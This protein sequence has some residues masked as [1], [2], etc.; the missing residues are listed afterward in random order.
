MTK[1]AMALCYNAHA[2]QVDKAGAP[3]V[4]HPYHLAEQM[5]NE[6]STTVALLHD[7]I[8][9]TNYTFDDLAREG[10]PDTVLDALRLLTHDKDVPYLDYVAKV[11]SNPVAVEVK[12]ADIEHNSDESR[13]D[14]VSPDVVRR[15]RKYVNAKKVL[16]AENLIEV[17]A[18]IIYDETGT[19]FL[20]CQRPENKT[21]GLLWEFVGGKVEPGE[22]KPDAL[23]RECREELAVEIEVTSRY[24]DVVHEYPDVT[25]LLTV[26]E[27]KIV[28]GEIKMLEH[29]DIRWVTPKEAQAMPFCPA[30]T[31]ILKKLS[32][33]QG[34]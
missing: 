32:G 24:M 25:V 34:I 2:G 7:V 3:Y 6:V 9:D 23:V 18:A 1:K 12:R 8:E 19:R 27:A 30:D 14:G 28:G 4:F 13:M 11:R 20:A 5:R 26:F 33:R 22:S 29:N 21:R 10:F 31:D 16:L 15:R 17:V